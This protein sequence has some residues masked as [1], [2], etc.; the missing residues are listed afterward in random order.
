M[1]AGHHAHE[2]AS[3]WTRLWTSA[4]IWKR[5]LRKVARER[6]RQRFASHDSRV[7]CNADMTPGAPLSPT[8]A[9]LAGLETVK[10]AAPFDISRCVTYNFVLDV[11]SI[12][13]SKLTVD[14]RPGTLCYGI[15]R[16][17]ERSGTPNLLNN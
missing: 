5:T 3:S 8:F 1:P 17:L 15:E 6:Q 11:Q 10:A 7:V 4:F 16:A 12:A 13:V 9:H 2:P 14:S